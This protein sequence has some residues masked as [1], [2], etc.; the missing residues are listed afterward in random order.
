LRDVLAHGEILGALVDGAQRPEVA[1]A[2]QM[3]EIAP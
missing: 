1:G 3:P 2:A